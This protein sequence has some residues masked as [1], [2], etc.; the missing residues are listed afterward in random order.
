MNR[1]ILYGVAA[2]GMWGLFPIYWKLLQHVP[3]LEIL[4]HRMTWSLGFVLLLLLVRRRWDWLKTAVHTPRTILLFIASALLLSVNWFVY[5][6]GVNAGF[7]VETS[8]GYFI[9]P[10]MNVLLGVLFL[11]ETMRRGQWVAIG[12]AALGVIYLTVRYGELPWIA[13]TLATS[14]ALYGLLRKTAPLGSLEGLSLETALMFFPAL[15]YLVYLEVAGTAA[16]GHVDMQTTMLLGFAGVATA[17]PLLLFAAAARRIKLATIG[18]LQYIAP[19]LQFLIGVLIYHEPF[20]MDRLVGF[21]LIW[22]AL[23][24]YSGENIW[25]SRRQPRLHPVGD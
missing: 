1:G 11:S 22:L 13:L 24:V 9:N 20:S 16:F 8:L 7:I 18:I 14:F 17:V 25:F 6:W 10:L 4:S 12:L 21:S 5:I 19:T 23:L 3:A 15:G 2:Y